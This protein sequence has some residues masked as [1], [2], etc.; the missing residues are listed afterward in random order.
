MALDGVD[1][2]RLA[3]IAGR[4][5]ARV[6]AKPA[7]QSGLAATLVISPGGTLLIPEDL[8]LDNVIRRADEALPLA[9]RS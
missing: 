5:R 7:V 8:N 6:E 3:E 9:Q 1:A 2:E 4:A